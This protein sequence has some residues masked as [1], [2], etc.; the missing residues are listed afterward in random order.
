MKKYVIAVH[1]GAGTIT[2]AKMSPEN[3]QAHIIGIEEA[4]TFGDE[5]L[6]SGGTAMDAVEAAV[7][8]LEDN[9]LF[10]AG[11]GA[12]F[13]H[14]GKNELDASIMDGKTLMAGAVSGVTNIKN[15]VA[16]A[17]LI[18][19]NTPHVLLCGSGAE[20]FARKMNVVFMPDAYFFTQHRFDQ[21]LAVYKTD[22]VQLDHTEGTTDLPNPYIGTAGA[23]ALDMDG[24][25]AAATSTGGMTN[26]KFGRAGDSPLI[27]AGTFANNATC[28]ISCTG[29]GEYFIRSVVAY[30]VSCLMEYKG[31]NL[32]AA[33]NY[34]VN[35][36][37]KLIGGEGGLIAVDARGNVALPFNSE[38]MY[39]GYKR[40]DE[41]FVIG[42][43]KE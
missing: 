17:R 31:M 19:E 40:N 35:N 29:H 37:L 6:K 9:P 13:T 8:S 7:K 25:I 18:M 2:K 10:N 16:L 4:L 11:R 1:G 3:E 26:K 34:V 38:G 28:A 24:N 5:I 43:Y 36:K 27:G 12:V 14:E 23:V 39:R 30:D 15:P 32:E 42:I 20:D 33:S 22:Q 41:D 21:Y